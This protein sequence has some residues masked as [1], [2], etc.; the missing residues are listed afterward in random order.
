MKKLQIS[1]LAQMNIRD[2]EHQKVG[3]ACPILRVSEKLMV[4][5]ITSA[6][7]VTALCLC[8]IAGHHEGHPRGH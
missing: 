5:F 4:H 6:Q 1:N 3:N 7:I 2:F 8:C